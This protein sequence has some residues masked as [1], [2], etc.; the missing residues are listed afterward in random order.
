MKKFTTILMIMCFLASLPVSAFAFE[1]FGVG[2]RGGYYKTQDADEGNMYVGAAARL[3]LGG[4]GFEGSFDYRSEEYGDG[5]FKV[6]SWPVNA[7]VLIYPL[8]IL[9]GIAGFG[10]Y[11]NTMEYTGSIALL[12]GLKETS[13]DVGYHFGGGAEIPLGNISIAADIRYVFIDYQFE[14]SP[15]SN[16]IKSDFYAVALSL[17]WGF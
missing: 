9:Y 3:K 6:T 17:L 10:W 2:P 16:D 12:N 7:S 1:L 5:N 11:N 8:P 14:T 15:T 13:Q 4:L